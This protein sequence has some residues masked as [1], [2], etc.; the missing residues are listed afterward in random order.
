VI[1]SLFNRREWVIG[2]VRALPYRRVWLVDFEFTA[3]PGCRPV[4][5]CVVAFDV[6]SGRLVRHWLTDGPVPCPYGTGPED[7]FTA[8]YASSEINCHLA[9]GWPVPCRVL[10]LCAEF[11]NLTSG[12][13]LDHGRDLLGAL[14][15]FRLD[16]MAA[17]EKKEMRELAI[18]GGPY[19][20]AECKA[21]IDYCERDVRALALLL[22]A[23]LPYINLA[24]ALIRG[25]YMVAAARIEDTG[26]P[27]NVERLATLR[28][29]WDGI[30][31]R[32]V[33]AVDRDYGVYTYS[34]GR[35]PS[36]SEA[37]WLKY[38]AG[39]GIWW[40]CLDSGRADLSDDVFKDMAK[41]YPAEVGP[42]RDLRHA[43]SQLKLNDLAV[44]PDG[45]NRTLLG[46]F[47]SKT[48][49][50]QPSNKKFIFGPSCWVRLLIEPPP[51]WAM[52]YIDWCGQEYGI[53]A[54]KSGDPLMMADYA[55]GEPY[56]AFGKR[57]GF[58]PAW[59]TTKT[60]PKER[61]MLKTATGLG[62]MYG[63]GPYTLANRLG[64]SP[65][66]AREILNQHRRWY[67]TFWPWSD[68]VRDFAMLHGY[69]ETEY[70]WRV[71][72]TKDTRPTSLRNFPMQA[73]GAEMLRLA[74]C[75][76][77]ERGVQVCDPIHDAVLI[78]APAR[79]IKAAV[80]ETRRAMA[81]AAELVVPGCGLRT[82]VKVITYPNRYSDSRGEGMWTKVWGLIGDGVNLLTGEKVGC[83]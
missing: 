80:A 49:R 22:P 28:A 38:T 24:H 73:T 29:N 1:A 20:E 55:S 42:I 30:K 45:R 3:K 52:T 8:Y 58:V 2:A 13:K 57:I 7:L 12:V 65:A 25:R 78:M 47:G 50:N 76:A 59:A 32:L 16:A 40:P 6:L 10:D 71:H 4:P 46:A 18:R 19:S 54:A 77:T 31:S 15:Y 79:S 74:C 61:G 33:E 27:V 82:D 68:S 5:L 17:V 48:G 62:A 11:K 44:G 72:V 81:E 51:G 39:K 26:T 70:G 63:A 60:H 14:L 53:A 35:P 66:A 37:L 43:L 64:I 9:L 36:F 69:L 23:M 56:L 34:P 83:S 67:S 41:A 75:L 21:L